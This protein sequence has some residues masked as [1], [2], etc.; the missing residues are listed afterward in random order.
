MLFD[1]SVIVII[2]V[3]SSDIGRELLLEFNNIKCYLR[4]LKIYSAIGP[5]KSKFAYVGFLGLEIWH[6]S[7]NT[8]F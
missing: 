6:L 8:E 5:K 2:F 1:V 3:I 7:W 4:I